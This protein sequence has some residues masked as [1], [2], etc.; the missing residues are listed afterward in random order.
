MAVEPKVPSNFTCIA[1]NWEKIN[2]TWDPPHNYVHTEYELTFKL[3]GGRRGLRR[4]YPCPKDCSNKTYCCWTQYTSPM[5]RQA[6]QD[7][8]FM[9]HIHNKFGSVNVTYKVDQFAQGM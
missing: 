5:Y 4:V 6:Y 8:I 3:S 2:C 9:M 1:R 7:Y